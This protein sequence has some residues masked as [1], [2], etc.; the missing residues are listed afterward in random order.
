MSTLGGEA[1]D[2]DVELA[3]SSR[4]RTPQVFEPFV[5][6]ASLETPGRAACS[7]R[8]AGLGVFARCA[9]M[10]QDLEDGGKKKTERGS[11]RK[12]QKS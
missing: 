4:A 1:L 9:C 7:L 8:V 12:L 11:P 2:K 5:D 3:L 10:N 6:A